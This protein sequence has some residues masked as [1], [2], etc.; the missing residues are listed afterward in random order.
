MKYLFRDAHSTKKADR[1]YNKCFFGSS[2]PDIPL[3][4]IKREKLRKL[5]FEEF[6][7]VIIDIK[8]AGNG[9][10]L[11]D[12]SLCLLCL[13][14]VNNTTISKCMGASENA[15]RTRKSRLKEKLDPQM[16]QFIFGR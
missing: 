10:N 2:V 12:L 15:I 1:R 13:L 7:D 16:Y 3:I 4:T 14:K 9:V 6:T 11:D 8:T 5:L